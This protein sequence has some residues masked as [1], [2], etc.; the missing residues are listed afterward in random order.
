MDGGVI[1]PDSDLQEQRVLLPPINVCMRE[2]GEPPTRGWK[3]RN[4]KRGGEGEGE[5]ERERERGKGKESTTHIPT[6]TN[7]S[8][9]IEDPFEQTLET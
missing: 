2:E 7:S 6:R 3:M 1:C 5:G 4:H 8:S 9:Q